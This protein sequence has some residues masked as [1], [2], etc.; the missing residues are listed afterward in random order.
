MAACSGAAFYGSV[1]EKTRPRVCNETAERILEKI[2]ARESSDLDLSDSDEKAPEDVAVWD[3]L[4]KDLEPDVDSSDK[5]PVHTV[6]AA[7]KRA[8]L[9]KTTDSSP[10][11]WGSDF[12][13]PHSGEVRVLWRPFEY[14]QKYIS[15]KCGRRCLPL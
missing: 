10:Q 1:R 13:T 11:A 9:S 14:F 3:D 7:S 4:E 15:D 5:E 6:P 8:A 2:A 12:V